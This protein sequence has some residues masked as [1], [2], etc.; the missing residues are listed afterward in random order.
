MSD[1]PEPVYY[2]LNDHVR[3]PR[4][5]TLSELAAMR[6]AGEI[7]NDAQVSALPP[8]PV[9]DLLGSVRS[10]PTEAAARLAG[11]I[12]LDR[13]LCFFDLETTGTLVAQDRIVEFA[14]AR[15]STDGRMETWVQRV[16]PTIPIPH[17]A[18]LCHGI[19]DEDVREMPT[20]RQVAPRIAE[21]LGES[22]L[23]GYNIIRFDIPLL[24]REFEM[25][26]VDWPWMRDWR[27][28]TVVDVM[29][30]YHGLRPRNLA[31][32]YLDL[33]GRPLVNAHTAEADVHATIQILA[34]LVAR[35]ELRGD[36]IEHWRGLVDSARTKPN[37]HALDFSGWFILTPDQDIYFNQGKRRGTSI[38]QAMQSG[39]PDGVRGFLRWMI[40]RDFAE[41]TRE[42]AQYLASNLPR[43]GKDPAR[44]EAGATALGAHQQFGEDWN[45]FIRELRGRF[46]I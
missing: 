33:C 18:T 37:H 41:S 12:R 9:G 22:D 15:V 16:N 11:R 36:R 20:F 10:G 39:D 26:G 17:D 34:G 43:R 42:V 29:N 2:L 4:G 23:A 45:A 30:I 32:A 27:N 28:R 21:F 5:Y 7:Q 44:T 19:S 38:R 25:A 6:E 31:A 3:A 1:R 14:A 24:A 40:D 13:P 35:G 46:G 8:L